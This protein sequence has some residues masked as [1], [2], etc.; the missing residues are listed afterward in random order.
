M[1]KCPLP[2]VPILSDHIVHAFLET[3]TISIVELQAHNWD[4]VGRMRHQNFH[5]KQCNDTERFDAVLKHFRHY[6]WS[7][8]IVVEYMW[9]PGEEGAPAFWS[10]GVL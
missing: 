10:A 2:E 3:F 9:I 5:V 6:R 4:T 1:T 7:T 8:L